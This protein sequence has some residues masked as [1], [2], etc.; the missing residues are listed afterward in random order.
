M[1]IRGIGVDVVDVARFAAAAERTPAMVERVLTSGERT[2]PIASQAARFA[3]KEALVKALG[4]P[5]GLAWHDVEVVGGSIDDTVPHFAA[6]RTVA[7]AVG[8]AR[9]HLSLSHDA[10]IATAYVV[11][12]D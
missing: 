6:T 3:A 12:E 11:V 1:S 2:L 5:R 7:E 8:S 4:S 10:G 9:L